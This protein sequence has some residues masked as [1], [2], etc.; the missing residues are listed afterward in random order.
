[1]TVKIMTPSIP[2]HSINDIEIEALV[3]QLNPLRYVVVL[4]AVLLSVV[5]PSSVY[6]FIMSVV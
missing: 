1:M 2:T 3:S 5:A 6:L 4:N